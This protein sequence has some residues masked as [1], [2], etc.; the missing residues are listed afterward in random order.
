MLATLRTVTKPEVPGEPYRFSRERY[1]AMIENGILGENDR[2]ELIAGEI[3]NKMPIGPIHAGTVKRV[4]QAFSRIVSER[5]IISV[6]DPIALDEFSQ[7]EPDI[8]LLRPRADFYSR[9]HPKPEHVFLLVEVADS[10]LLHDRE[11]KIPLY[12]AAGIPEVWLLNLV[13]KA[14]FRYRNPYDGSYREIS[15]HVSGENLSI[16]AL[17][18]VQ[19]GLADL[20]L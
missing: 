16:A 18:D 11:R 4:N 14:L 10:S 20:G 13:E 9:S 6:Q 15:R 8:A 19:V 17:G 1:E 3:I 2:V 12:A 5:C 7:P